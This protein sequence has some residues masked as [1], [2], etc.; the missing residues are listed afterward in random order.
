MDASLIRQDPY[1]IACDTWI[2]PQLEPA[3][4]GTLVSINSMVITAAE[5]VIVDTGCAINRARWIDQVFSIVEPADVRWIF[6][7]H[8][9]RDHIGN[10]NALLEACPKATLLS[11]YWGVIYSIPDGVPPLHRM[12]WVN[13]GETFHAGDRT[14]HAICPPTWDGANTRGLFDPTTGVYWVADSF[15]SFITHPITNAAEL[16]HDFWVD[17]FLRENRLA[18]G[19][20]S[21]LDPTK[22]DAHVDLSARLRPSVIASAHGPVLTGSYVEE[23]YHMTRQLAR[24]DPV[25][26]PGQAVLDQMV[27]AIAAA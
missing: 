18:V 6:L 15:A 24:L 21:L 25:D 11:T 14:L 20:H 8:G 16:D 9:D 4:P 13:D 27:A 2:V 12:R 23:G 5:P 7:S 3:G 19:W 17:S 26:Q 10:V 1:R 22:F